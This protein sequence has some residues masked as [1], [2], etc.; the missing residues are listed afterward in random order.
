MDKEM[1]DELFFAPVSTEDVI[2]EE[3]VAAVTRDDGPNQDVKRIYV[4]EETQIN[5]DPPLQIISSLK[6][7]EAIES[8]QCYG[9]SRGDDEVVTGCVDLGK[10]LERVSTRR[11]AERVQLPIGYFFSKDIK[12]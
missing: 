6:A 8:I 12:L 10:Y 5:E 9:M 1:D 2:M 3:V 4:V 7:C 11:I